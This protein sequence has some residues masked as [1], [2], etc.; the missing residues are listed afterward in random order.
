MFEKYLNIITESN[1][2]NDDI[3]ELIKGLD[4]KLI[5]ELLSYKDFNDYYDSASLDL[6][7][8]INPIIIENPDKLYFK[9]ND[10][11]SLK[12]LILSNSPVKITNKN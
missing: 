10:F 9:N 12:K 4:S 1:Y 3:K 8:I 11:R 6:K 2:I 5:T 7:Q